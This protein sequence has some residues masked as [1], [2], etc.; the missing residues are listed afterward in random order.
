MR[1][2]WSEPAQVQRTNLDT[3]YLVC[4]ILVNKRLQEETIVTIFGVVND[5]ESVKKNEVETIVRKL[6]VSYSH[7][8]RSFRKKEKDI[9][10]ALDN[11]NVTAAI[12][13]LAQVYRLPSGF[14]KRVG[15]SAKIKSPAAL[16]SQ[17]DFVRNR[18]IECT[19]YFQDSKAGLLRIPRYRF[20]H[21]TA[22]EL[23]HARMQRDIHPLHTSEFATDVLALLATGDSKGYT[24]AMVNDY[25]QYGYIRREL[26]DELFRC[27]NMYADRIYLS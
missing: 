21:M 7:I 16:N 5:S 11:S 1:N 4:F 9:N 3:I 2:T 23:A 6:S 27:L 8:R 25:I 22:H 26:L 12:Q 20:L 10:L 13:I 15:Y 19:V 24:D 14:V 18:V 17:F